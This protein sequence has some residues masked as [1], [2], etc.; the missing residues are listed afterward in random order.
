MIPTS[1]TLKQMIE[2]VQSTSCC[3]LCS[4]HRNPL[5]GRQ[6]QRRQVARP[7]GLGALVTPRIIIGALGVHQRQAVVAS[8]KML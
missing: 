6:N 4:T 8:G 1:Q 2:S 5:D 7:L 3:P